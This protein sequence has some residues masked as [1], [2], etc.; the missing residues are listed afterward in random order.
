MK[1]TVFVVSHSYFEN[2][3]ISVGCDMQPFTSYTFF[4][5]QCLTWKF[6]ASLSEKGFCVQYSSI[7]YV[8]VYNPIKILS[9]DYKE[10]YY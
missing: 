7:Q 9:N 8:E 5:L 2:A 10:S 4:F 3:A 6:Q 1:G